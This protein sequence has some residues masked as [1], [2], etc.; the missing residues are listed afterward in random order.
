MTAYEFTVQ[1]VVVEVIIG[2]RHQRMVEL[3]KA[4]AAQHS[5]LHFVLFDDHGS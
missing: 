3:T 1:K 4:V 5:R 2:L